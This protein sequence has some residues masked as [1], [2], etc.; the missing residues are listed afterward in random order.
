MYAV[1]VRT[2]TQFGIGEENWWKWKW[3]RR[4]RKRLLSL[5]IYKYR[6]LRIDFR[7]GERRF[8]LSLLKIVTKTSYSRKR[9][10]LI[11]LL[12]PAFPRL[13]RPV[14]CKSATG[15]AAMCSGRGSIYG[16][17]DFGNI[18]MEPQCFRRSDPLG[19][20]VTRK[21]LLSTTGVIVL[22]LACGTALLLA[23]LVEAGA[24]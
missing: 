22:G 6:K 24:L 5:Q 13:T 14:P 18:Y 2:S 12:S 9:G 17:R 19:G 10:F 23:G 15:G 4:E 1:L 16:R 3:K 20:C 8:F 7:E 11:S 21:T